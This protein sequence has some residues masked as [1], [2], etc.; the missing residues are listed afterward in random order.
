M[1]MLQQIVCFFNY[2]FMLFADEPTTNTNLYAKV[3]TKVYD[4]YGIDHTQEYN[5]T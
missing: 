1:P 3:P 5:K 4:I 2:T